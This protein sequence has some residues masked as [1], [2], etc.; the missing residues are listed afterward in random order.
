M[1]NTLAFSILI[2]V[3]LISEAQIFNSLEISTGLSMA[4]QTP[5]YKNN[6]RNQRET[7]RPGFNTMLRMTGRINKIFSF[8][9]DIGYVQKGYRYDVGNTIGITKT[10]D[11]LIHYITYSPQLKIGRRIG[12]FTPTVFLGPRIDYQIA[13]EGKQKIDGMARY[14]RK[15]IFGMNA[16]LDFAYAFGELG[17]S[18]LF[19]Y[20]FDFT[21]LIPTN[22]NADLAYRNKAL[23]M[24]IGL[25]YFLGD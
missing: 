13:Y 17:I 4:T 22:N 23:L 7:I 8:S 18:A 11:Q 20:Q 25:V 24:N 6:D 1:K 15:S 16:G 5:A 10:Y 2:F 12:D 3:V 9:S 19:L 21:S 14:F